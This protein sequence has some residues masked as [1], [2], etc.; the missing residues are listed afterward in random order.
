MSFF[1]KF[2]YT[3]YHELNLDW[4]ISQ[5]S[6][7]KDS[8]LKA[9]ESAKNAKVSE[10]NAKTSETNAKTS[11]T[12]AKTSETNA[13]T[14]ADNAKTSET[15]AKISE[16]KAKTSEDKA[17]VSETNA[18]TSETNSKTSADKA[19]ISETNAKAS[20]DKAKI[21]ETN[22][23]T[24]ETNADDYKNDAEAS[25]NKALEYLQQS[26]GLYAQLKGTANYFD[27]G[28]HAGELTAFKNV[29]CVIRNNTLYIYSDVYPLFGATQESNILTVAN[30][31]STGGSLSLDSKIDADFSIKEWV[32]SVLPSVD[33]DNLTVT[34]CGVS[35]KFNN[36]RYTYDSTSQTSYMDYTP[37]MGAVLETNTNGKR[38]LRYKVTCVFGS[39][40]LSDGK[41]SVEEQHN[42]Y[43]PVCITIPLKFTDTTDVTPI[44]LYKPVYYDNKNNINTRCIASFDGTYL[45][46]YLSK[47]YRIPT[48]T[49]NEP[50]NGLPCVK[51]L[52]HYDRNDITAL[53]TWI[54]E[55]KG[56]KKLEMIV[57]DIY[58]DGF[59]I[60]AF[61]NVP[62]KSDVDYQ[63]NDI[64][65]TT[66]AT[67]TYFTDTIGK[68]NN[69]KS[70]FD[71]AS[72][73]EKSLDPITHYRFLVTE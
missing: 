30:S 60:T 3:N 8:M 27:S 21:S 24:S 54:A 33:W 72:S 39:K 10:D 62:N 12:N 26:A 67:L 48:V 71:S 45:D 58:I 17:K 14:S 51:A 73:L 2:P 15:N 68:A 44:D 7:V 20:E 22:A 42:I 18:K 49:V 66:T 63:F 9:V 57:H 16:T 65:T 55:A 6:T 43:C 40:V 1:D 56:S 5:I 4:I 36:F 59:A 34:D 69:L 19:K 23:K 29:E 38:Y 41:I 13:K 37:M 64:S 35:N 25:K 28:V 50:L 61:D 53:N 46:V 32:D 47:S 11:E 31:L 70:A 52:V